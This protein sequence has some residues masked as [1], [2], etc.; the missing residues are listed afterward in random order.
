MRKVAG[1]P[2]QRFTAVNETATA[3]YIIFLRLLPLLLNL[4]FV[5]YVFCRFSFPMSILSFTIHLGIIDQ[6]FKQIK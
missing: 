2:T 1:T 4:L 6:S 5:G 3:H